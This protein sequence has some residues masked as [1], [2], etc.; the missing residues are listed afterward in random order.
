MGKGEDRLGAVA[1]ALGLGDALDRYRITVGQDEGDCFQCFRHA[2]GKIPE[3]FGHRPCF[4]VERA[5]DLNQVLG[6]ADGRLQRADVIDL[7]LDDKKS[8]A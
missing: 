1:A 3:E 7:A 4:V 5:V 8:D 6:T 2:V